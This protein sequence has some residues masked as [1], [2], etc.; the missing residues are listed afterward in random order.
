MCKK[1][2]KKGLELLLLPNAW[3]WIDHC[4][5]KWQTIIMWKT[6]M[7]N[8]PT[9]TYKCETSQQAT[10]FWQVASAKTLWQPFIYEQKN[11][12]QLTN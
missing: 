7:H 12:Q 8:P 6:N 3:R 2:K 11:N 10:K 5:Y 1:I 9:T 4:D